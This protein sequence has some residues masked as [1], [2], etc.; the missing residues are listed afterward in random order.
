MSS[1]L[2]DAESI[3]A[4]IKST[5]TCTAETVTTLS[6]LLLPSSSLISENR[7]IPTTN[8]RKTI[9]SATNSKSK[10]QKAPAKSRGKKV[11]IH[12]QENQHEDV[13]EISQKARSILAT[14]VINATLKSLTEAIKAPPPTPLRRQPSSRDLIKTSSRRNLRRSNSLPQSPQQPRTLNRVSSS[15]GPAS[16]V[17]RSASSAALTS[18]G[19][20]SLAECARIAFACLR[21]LQAAQIPSVNLPPLQ[22]ENGMSVLVGKLIT[23]G[24]DDL[25]VK[26]VRLLRRRLELKDP[27]KKPLP[28]KINGL[29]PPQDLP[30]LLDFGTATFTGPKLALVISTQL[31]I[32][33]LMASTKNTNI[34]VSILNPQYPSSPT[35][36]LMSSVTD[37]KSREKTSRQLQNLS[38]ILLSLCPSVATSEDALAVQTKLSVDPFIAYQLQSLALQTRLLSWTLLPRQADFAN[39]LFEPFLRCLSAYARRI[40]RGTASKFTATVFEGLYELWNDKL[41]GEQPPELSQVFFDIYRIL[42]S[43]LQERG[44]VEDALGL[45]LQLEKHAGNSSQARQTFVVA[46]QVTI[47]L[48][49]IKRIPKEEELLMRLLDLLE[50]PYT[51]SASDIDDL[52]T[53]VS[54]ARR[55]AIA[56]VARATPTCNSEHK[57]TEGMRQM[58]ETLVFLCPR[59]C[60]RYLGKAPNSNAATKDVV[61]Y[62]QRRMFIKKFGLH[63][64]DSTLFLVKT[65]LN[66][67]RM[68]WDLMDSK[69]QDCLTLVDQIGPES[70]EPDSPGTD[71]TPSSYVRISN[72]YY[73]HFLNERRNSS[74][75]KVTQQLRILRRSID[76]IRTRSPSEKKAALSTTKLERMAE[77]YKSAGRYDELLQVFKTMR[78]DL[79]DEGVL[80]E[81]ATA[82]ASQPLRAAWEKDDE[83]SMFARAVHTLLKI[84]TKYFDTATQNDSLFDASWSS[85]ETAAMAEHLLLHL[86][87]QTKK[88]GAVLKLQSSMFKCLLNTYNND[89]YPV[90]RLRVIIEL[91]GVDVSELGE[92]LE[93]FPDRMQDEIYMVKDNKIKVEETEDRELKPYLE[94]FKSLAATTFELQQDQP[95]IKVLESNVRIW[96]KMQESCRSLEAL[97]R[98]FEDIEGFIGHLQTIASYL[99]VKGHNTIRITV[100]D[101]ISQLNAQLRDSLGDDGIVSSLVAMGSQWL[102]LG[103]SGKAGLALDKAQTCSASNGVSLTTILQFH[104]AYSEYLLEIGNVDKR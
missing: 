6:D 4:A 33:R 38:D 3:R 71:S 47:S 44:S 88:S 29:Q 96:H 41:V 81:I 36:L 95:D 60:L 42:S 54:G 87:A 12:D 17:A 50:S 27:T 39:D 21:S 49:A 53:E 63:S 16:R 2:A 70:E 90:R 55:T 51:G 75:V 102:H 28:T 22:L 23:L 99:Q 93:D 62:E 97:K 8:A 92:E 14:E 57:L 80:S 13:H 64:L 72:L 15:P 34:D 59:L 25:A 24:L 65:L 73:T 45:A 100:L 82:L 5:S 9:T 46:R 37:E 91:M 78:D 26:E 10:P 61:R 40:R 101:L 35:S 11:Q 7:S 31:Q 32:L 30:Q 103:Y 85:I 20:R 94:Y 69:L 77:L 84:Q 1:Y 52:M 67:G 104:L 68:S 98:Q 66:D 79:V 48:K 19:P 74:G 83:A 86:C 18:P 43:L 89:Q 76:C 56:L 58:C